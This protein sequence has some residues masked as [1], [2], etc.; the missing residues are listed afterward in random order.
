MYSPQNQWYD[1]EILGEVSE[2][3]N[4]RRNN[5]IELG[6]FHNSEALAFWKVIPLHAIRQSFLYY[7]VCANNI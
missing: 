1:I 3:T 4:V 7:E 2:E 5:I 6:A